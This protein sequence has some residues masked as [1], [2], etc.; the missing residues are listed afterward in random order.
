MA[1][2]HNARIAILRAT[3][4]DADRHRGLKGLGG[5][6]SA[7]LRDIPLY[8]GR[9]QGVVANF[10]ARAADELDTGTGDDSHVTRSLIDAAEDLA[11]AGA[12]GDDRNAD[13]A[14]SDC[15]SLPEDGRLIAASLR[16]LA[17]GLSTD[18]GPLI[19]AAAAWA[20][21]TAAQCHPRRSPCSLFSRDPRAFS[22]YSIFFCYDIINAAVALRLQARLVNR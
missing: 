3:E 17:T 4:R 20:S 21:E 14:E 9:L 11:A 8:A 13:R 5:V 6:E 22:G 7:E 12:L 18:D 10:L 19:A 1:P 15:A 2:D 16:E